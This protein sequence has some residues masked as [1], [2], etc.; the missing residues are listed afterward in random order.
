M[1]DA[2]LGIT[3]ALLRAFNLGA[4]DIIYNV[5]RYFAYTILVIYFFVHGKFIAFRGY[6]ILFFSL[7]LSLILGAFY[8]NFNQYYLKHI[9]SFSLPI[10]GLI[11]G[12]IAFRYNKEYLEQITSLFVKYAIFAICGVWLYFFLYIIGIVTYLGVSN[13]MVLVIAAS[14]ANKKNSLT[15]LALVGLALAG[16]RSDLICGLII[17]YVFAKSKGGY[18]QDILFALILSIFIALIYYFLPDVVKRFALIYDA[19]RE[20]DYQNINLDLLNLATSGRIHDME[21]ALNLIDEPWKFI[22]GAGAGYWYFLDAD[23]IVYYSHF[24]PISYL[25]LGGGILLC[26][27]WVFI[28]GVFFNSEKSNRDFYYYAALYYVL[29]S[30]IGGAVLFTSIFG[31]FCIGVVYARNKE[32]KINTKRKVSKRHILFEDI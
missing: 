12:I 14:F 10:I 20:I 4:L 27:V 32:N 17:L 13:A 26:W 29:I 2:Y 31:W 9:I 16:K 21:L 28:F 8:W 23:Y 3:P 25:V 30:L 5:L 1:L 11:T 18:F 24:T 7:F 6:S 15:F 19:L 22:T